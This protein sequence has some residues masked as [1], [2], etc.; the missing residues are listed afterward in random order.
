VNPVTRPVPDDATVSVFDPDTR[1]LVRL[2]GVIA[3]GSE[4]AMRLH[5]AAARHL[6]A[7]W[8]DEVLLQSYLFAGFPRT[9]NA[10][11][12]WRRTSGHAAPSGD[13]DAA[14]PV[15]AVEWRARGE[16]TCA[17][18]YGAMYD[19]LRDN[20]AA[21]HP[22]ID[23]W[24]VT[25][26]YGKVLSRPGLDLV[27]RELCVIA[28]CALARQDRQL[29]SHLHGAL[30]V[31]ATA[32]DVTATLDALE[33]LLDADSSTRYRLLWARVRAAHASGSTA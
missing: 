4:E 9:L 18:V 15:N 8:V 29:H 17:R 33:E 20:V 30:N 32:G 19:K 11:R 31:G 26:G 24:M 28:A 12:E 23:A 21:L 14:D 16:V 13:R 2:A 25:D 1:L 22:A 10:L 3:A 7:P 27:R 6:P 5:I